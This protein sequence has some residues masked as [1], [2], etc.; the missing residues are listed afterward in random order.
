MVDP[1]VPTSALRGELVEGHRLG[2]LA[3]PSPGPA[4][5]TTQCLEDKAALNSEVL[6]AWARGMDQQSSDCSESAL[7]AGNCSAPTSME[8]Y[9]LA[10]ERACSRH[11]GR[12]CTATLQVIH[13]NVSDFPVCK[14]STCQQSRWQSNLEE[15]WEAVPVCG[16]GTCNPFVECPRQAVVGFWI[17][18]LV[19][20]PLLLAG[21]CFLFWRRT[22][23]RERASTI[24]RVLDAQMAEVKPSNDE[25]PRW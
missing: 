3:T 23:S 11:H 22:K 14:P 12:L 24:S 15:S 18:L 7:A 8:T 13:S 16:G 1:Y 9:R 19:G 5:Q 6:V 10:V 4:A 21:C 2:L 20:V 25:R 17:F